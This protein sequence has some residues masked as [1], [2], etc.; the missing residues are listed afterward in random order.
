MKARL[1]D[2]LK[3]GFRVEHCVDLYK[4]TAALAAA[5][6]EELKPVTESS[7]N[8]SWESVIEPEDFRFII[9]QGGRT[10]FGIP[11]LFQRYACFMSA[12][13]ED[14]GIEFDEDMMADDW[15][16]DSM[17]KTRAIA[18]ALMELAVD[19]LSEARARMKEQ[20]GTTPAEVFVQSINTGE[21]FEQ[22]RTRLSH[23]ALGLQVVKLKDK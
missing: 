8:A 17:P 16:S 21:S 18:S 1:V 19:Y 7:I 4:A 22:S 15:I 5:I 2:E 6:T 14:L 9:E 3:A 23:A 12:L 20:T 10:L 11:L 13:G